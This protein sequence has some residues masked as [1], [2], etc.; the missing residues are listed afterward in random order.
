MTITDGHFADLGRRAPDDDDRAGCGEPIRLH[1]AQAG[2]A[3]A[4]LLLMLHGFPEAWHAWRD[5]MPAFED[6]FH[7]VAPDQ[8][9]Y[10]R[11]SRPAQV[12]AYRA[13]ELIGDLDALIVATGHQTAVVVAHD[14]GGAIAWGLALRHPERIS[15]LVILNAPHPVP[16]ARALVQ[17][18][19]QRQASEYMNRLRAPGSE[20]RL[21]ENDF[22]RLDRMLTG[23]GP[24]E[25]FDDA[26]RH[27][28]HEAW[29]QPGALTGMVNWYR[30][31][32]MHPPTPTDPGAA[33]L[34]LD[35]N[36]FRIRVPTRVIWGMDDTALLPVLLDG[37]E[38]MGDDLRVTRIDG[39]SHWLIHEAPARIGA[40]IRLQLG[41]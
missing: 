36:D 41:H 4:P 25:W 21:A 9:G 13:P 3:G 24:A 17:D 37:L 30:A 35:P 15:R 40:E 26:T 10:N 31:T 8:R 27:R 1:Y 33:R 6:D 11:S 22:Q 2:S 19:A 14:W 28:Y 38:T 20:A 32:P 7:V 23:F 34:V 29:R 16:F 18:P 39:V 5:L 12:S